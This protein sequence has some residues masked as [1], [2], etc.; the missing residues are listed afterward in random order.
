MQTCEVLQFRAIAFGYR[1]GFSH[2][3]FSGWSMEQKIWRNSNGKKPARVCEKRNKYMY[4]EKILIST[5]F[6]HQS[7][8]SKTQKTCSGPHSY[9][10][11][12]FPQV[13]KVRSITRWQKCQISF[14]VQLC[15]FSKH[16]INSIDLGSTAGLASEF[17]FLGHWFLKVSFFSVYLA[18]VIW[19]VYDHIYRLVAI[20]FI[21]YIAYKP[22][23]YVCHKKYHHSSGCRRPRKKVLIVVTSWPK[24]T[25]TVERHAPW[26]KLQCSTSTLAGARLWSL[27]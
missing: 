27:R 6:E 24:H 9:V 4:T 20:N 2:V 16:K 26:A 12:F 23:T 11:C 17:P 7:S 15:H 10:R 21:I 22:R 13:S 3:R 18:N 5:Q 25:F 14:A 1:E 19:C 8:N